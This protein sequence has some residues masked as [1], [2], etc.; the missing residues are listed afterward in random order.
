M[1]VSEFMNA[2]RQ[3]YPEYMF[4]RD[5][6]ALQQLEA[7]LAA[8]GAQSRY[9]AKIEEIALRYAVANRGL[10]RLKADV[11]GFMSVF[12]D[13]M[14]LLAQSKKRVAVKERLADVVEA[15]VEKLVARL[16]MPK[17]ALTGLIDAHCRSQQSVVVADVAVR[18]QQLQV[19]KSFYEA[20]FSSS[21]AMPEFVQRVVDVLDRSMANLRRGTERLLWRPSKLEKEY[22]KAEKKKLIDRMSRGCLGAEAK[23]EQLANY[24]LANLAS[25]L[26]FPK[27]CSTDQQQQLISQWCKQFAAPVSKADCYS[28][29][30]I[31]DS[32]F[33][34]M[35]YR[36][37]DRFEALM[38]NICNVCVDDQGQKL[39][40]QAAF[41]VEVKVIASMLRG[42]DRLARYR[43]REHMPR[44]D[45]TPLNP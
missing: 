4:K 28:G 24:L 15:S 6:E 31:A 25:S 37:R 43:S 16:G 7:E 8:P 44:A 42:L 26:T 21:A 12:E 36:S 40:G 2:M 17:G 14:I 19:A 45:R 9:A 34:K 3:R 23:Y 33:I 5:Q 32:L 20:A 27:M 11:I 18:L 38:R 29:H 30:S 35:E 41:N 22:L 10:I 13:A 1:R 39:S